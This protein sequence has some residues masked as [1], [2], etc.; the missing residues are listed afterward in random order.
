[1]DRAR[2]GLQATLNG[3]LTKAA[4]GAAPV[5][6]EELARDAAACVAA[7]ARCPPAPPRCGGVR[8]AGCGGCRHDCRAGPHRVRGPRRR[9]NRRLDRARSRAA[10]RPRAGLA[11][12]RLRVGQPV[13][14]GRA[15]GHAGADPGRGRHRGRRLDR[16]GRRATR[17]VRLGRAG[18]A[19][20]GRA[21]RGRRH[22]RPGRR[23]P[24]GAGQAR[25]DDAAPAARRR[26]GHL[27]APRRCGSPRPGHADR[28]RRHAARSGRGAHDGQRGA[29]PRRM[30]AWR[31]RRLGR[32]R[33]I[34]R[35]GVCGAM[36]MRRGTCSPQARGS[37]P[38]V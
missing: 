17:G 23:H 5:S 29:R 37:R 9:V 36:V 7:G 38:P 10:P 18:H 34:D 15:G 22:G 12:P 16:Q 6:V 4:H 35:V 1:M 13:R 32:A 26:G 14:A 25:P 27:S 21:G 8:T 2:I 11:R 28:A 19:H 24:P 3:D 20:P 30:R 31:R 33:R